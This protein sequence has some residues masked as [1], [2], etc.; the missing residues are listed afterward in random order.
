MRQGRGVLKWV[1]GGARPIR[2]AAHAGLI[3]TAVELQNAAVGLGERQRE[4]SS[5]V[6][7]IRTAV[8]AA[9]PWFTT[10]IAARRVQ[11]RGS[12]RVDRDIGI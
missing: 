1:G 6:A 9:Y 4:H 8:S 12:N 3:R 11:T 5:I 2:V 7:E 10:P